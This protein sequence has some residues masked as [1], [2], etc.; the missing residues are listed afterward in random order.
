[1]TPPDVASLSLMSPG[2]S[3]HR[4][5]G[6]TPVVCMMRIVTVIEVTEDTFEN[7]NV[8]VPVYPLE[9]SLEV[10]TWTPFD[11][12]VVVVVVGNVVV[13]DVGVVVVVVVVDGLNPPV[14]AP[15]QALAEL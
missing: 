7:V 9:L 2:K 3:F 6:V 12:D 14:F 10:A 13:V 4:L 5:P 1:M 11:G 8:S 15:A